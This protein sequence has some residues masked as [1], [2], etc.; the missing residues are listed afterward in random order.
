[1][2]ILQFEVN[3]LL[4]GTQIQPSDRVKCFYQN[5]F[6]V[7]SIDEVSE[8]DAG[9]YVFQAENEIGDAETSATVRQD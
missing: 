1:M 7:L 3:F 6:V 5:G 9:F 4:N 2:S 8:K